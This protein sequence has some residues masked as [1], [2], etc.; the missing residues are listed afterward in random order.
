MNCLMVWGAVIST[1]PGEDQLKAL[2]YPLTQIIIGTVNLVSAAKYFPMRFHCVDLLN[3]LAAAT[4]GTLMPIPAL[5]LDVLRSPEFGKPARG[6]RKPPRL[7][8]SVKVSS[9]ELQTKGYQESCVAR[10]L[11]LID[12]HFQIHKWSISFPELAHSTV[13]ALR[14]FSR[15]SQVARWRQQCKAAVARIERQSEAVEAKRNA[16]SFGP[17]DLE[18]AKAFMINEAVSAHRAYLEQKRKTEEAE[19]A[20][21]EKA[22]AR[23]SKKNKNG[24]K[25][26]KKRAASS[27]G[28]DEGEHGDRD[29]GGRGGRGGKRVKTAAAAATTA[30]MDGPA[31]AADPRVEGDEDVVEDMVLSDSD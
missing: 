3:K 14:K 2:V 8:Y 31:P 20:A 6:T 30:A 29:R 1:Y 21:S 15:D 5:L 11:E 28:G 4:G 19:V 13:A 10:A 25:E 9:K 17:K 22:A 7:E 16:V 12:H 26:G 24:K 23:D 18:K 27:E